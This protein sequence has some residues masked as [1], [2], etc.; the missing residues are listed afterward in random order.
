MNNFININNAEI[1]KF[2]NKLEKL[3]KSAMPV[4]VRQT[5]NDA[6]FDA[7]KGLIK[8]FKKNFIIR[9]RT[10]ITSHTAVN[11]CQNTFDINKM[12]SET[13]IIKGKTKSGDLLEKQEIGGN[14]QRQRIPGSSV[15]MGSNFRKPVVRQYYWNKFKNR[16][17]GIIYKSGESTIIKSKNS[18]F[19]IMRG[20]KIATMYTLNKNVTIKASPFLEPASNEAANNLSKFFIQN[21]QKR[22]QKYLK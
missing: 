13:G 2:T 7:R 17:N 21:A 9:N 19:R 10:F 1:V 16:K 5:L 22:F 14:I 3:H 18:L 8:K 6:A 12:V 20:G 15:R 11:K 4:A